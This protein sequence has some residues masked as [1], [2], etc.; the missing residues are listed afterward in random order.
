MN[1]DFEDID[2][3][4]LLKDRLG[5]YQE[6]P[7]A[8]YWERFERNFT[9][10]VMSYR[11]FNH[12][13]Y[14]L[15]VSIAVAATLA[16][17]L[18]I[19][20]L[21]TDIS[22]GQPDL[23]RGHQTQT[24]DQTTNGISGIP[25]LPSD[26][27][28]NPDN[29]LIGI[30]KPL[31]QQAIADSRNK[32]GAFQSN[33]TEIVENDINQ[34]IRKNDQLT[35]SLTLLNPIEYSSIGEK[36]VIY[37]LAFSPSFNPSNATP[38][39]LKIKKPRS[40][41][42]ATNKSFRN[43]TSPKH[44]F[45]QNNFKARTSNQMATSNSFLIR[46]LSKLEFKI[47]VTPQYQ[48]QTLNN[49]GGIA[50]TDYDPQYYKAI[51]KGKYALSG[52]LEIV[53][54]ISESWSVYSGLKLTEYKRETTNDLSHL[55]I[56]NGQI[57]APTSA[58]D[59]L[60]HG[61]TE[62]QLTGKTHFVTKLRLQSVEIPLIVRYQP[63]KNFYLDGGFLYSYLIADKTLTNLIGSDLNFTFDLI[64]GIRKHNLGMIIGTG[65]TFITNSGIKFDA[66][67]EISWNLTSLNTNS[68]LLNKRLTFGI[69]TAISLQRFQ[70]F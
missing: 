38:D 42:F 57:T 34:A 67:P 56:V 14:T 53:Y 4:Q 10:K 52:G 28:I 50:S 43:V 61:L 16:I 54:P 30:N 62:N 8:E 59:I 18:I 47:N 5:E 22:T 60:I 65:F 25:H 70:Q 13:R 21:K 63:G 68:D 55:K 9:P 27:N 17:M 45:K 11:R 58:G 33:H 46:L 40:P 20:N 37:P 2:L 29:K 69:R 19:S 1:H 23:V 12:Y 51:E 49:K 41:L 7:S 36:S 26:P 39:L 6:A 48:S 44:L 32:D 35:A 24:T 31:L 3:D 66:G 64:S 15:Y